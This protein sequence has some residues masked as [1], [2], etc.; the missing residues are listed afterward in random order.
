LDIHFTA[1]TSCER[2]TPLAEKNAAARHHVQR[3]LISLYN[4]HRVK[5]TCL[6]SPFKPEFLEWWISETK[7]FHL[8]FQNAHAKLN[9]HNAQRLLE[10]KETR[11]CPEDA[12]ICSELPSI[13]SL[14]NINRLGL[15]TETMYFL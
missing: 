7:Y 6:F 10:I 5:L 2:A 4:E 12:F 3:S 11:I 13:I 8:V 14:D 1:G 9:L 15:I